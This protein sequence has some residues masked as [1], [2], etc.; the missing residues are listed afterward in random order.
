MSINLAAIKHKDEEE[1]ATKRHEKNKR[2]F[3]IFCAFCAFC[4]SLG[5][6]DAVAGLE[7]GILHGSR[8]D[9]LDREANRHETAIR[10]F[11]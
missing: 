4:G 5:D 1:L 3:P 10:A 6:F 8:F 11:A 2:F 9:L 7:F